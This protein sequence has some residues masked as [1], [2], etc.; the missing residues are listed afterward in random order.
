MSTTFILIASTT[1]WFNVIVSALLLILA[2]ILVFVYLAWRRAKSH[3]GMIT[4]AIRK[5]AQG[6]LAQILVTG[7]KDGSEQ[8]T[9]DYNLMVDR[10]LSERA[11]AGLE[12]RR[13]EEILARLADGI[14]MTDAEGKIILANPAVATMFSFQADKAEGH[15]IIEIVH[16]HEVDAIYR[17]CLKTKHEERQRI[18]TRSHFLQVIAAPLPLDEPAGAILLFQD[19]TQLF[20]LQTVRQEFVA[21]VSH[22]L[23]TP[24]AGIK[25]MV[26]TLQEG[27]IHDEK[28]AADFLTRIDGEID[29][30]TQ[31]VNELMELS[32]IETGELKLKLESADLNVLLAESA[33]RFA[34]QAERK[35]LRLD[36]KLDPQMPSV[37]LDNPRISEV[38]DN[39][40]HNALKFTP[41]GGKI[42][43]A[44]NHDSSSVTASISDTGI[45]IGAADLPHVFERFYKADR[46]R[47]QGGTGLGLA[48]AKHIIQAHGGKIWAESTPSKGS[49]FSFSLPLKPQF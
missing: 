19:L 40:L 13:L 22:E 23:R 7:A 25:A 3:L 28:T 31:M 9:R 4:T 38:I 46:S 32:R 44:S 45:G 17:K 34:P 39:I 5:I 21:N 15:S 20:A 35:N 16:D 18:D 1:V 37:S 33:R 26:E 41:E 36:L 14:I 47:A 8:I 2:A 6:D 42:T 24:L 30:L 11:R 27:A 12:K 10:L 48:I 29:K 49:T 43:L